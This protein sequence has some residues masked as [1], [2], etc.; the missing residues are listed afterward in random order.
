MQTIENINLYEM[1]STTV[2]RLN[3]KAIHKAYK[4]LD[5]LSAELERKMIKNKQKEANKDA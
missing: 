3:Q 1:T 2:R 4:Q 5:D